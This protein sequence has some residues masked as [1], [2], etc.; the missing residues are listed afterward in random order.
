[1]E[2]H[3]CKWEWFSQ[4]NKQPKRLK[5]NLKNFRPDWESNTDVWDGRTQR[6]IRSSHMESRPL[7]NRNIPVGGN[8]MNGNIW[9]DS[10]LFWTAEPSKKIF[11]DVFDS[12]FT[13][14]IRICQ[15]IKYHIHNSKYIRFDLFDPKNI[16]ETVLMERR[17]I[18]HYLQ[19]SIVSPLLS[20]MPKC[21]YIHTL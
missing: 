6:S 11:L 16:N 20:F 14:L 21:K 10:Y 12:I 13:V 17:C 2:G 3:I 5:K 4:L 1:M 7:R 18:K 9:N 15:L 8:D 19:L